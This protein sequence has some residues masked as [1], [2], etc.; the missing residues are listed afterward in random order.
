[1]G[2]LYK[3]WPDV[4][5]RYRSIPPQSVVHVPKKDWQ[6][7]CQRANSHQAGTVESRVDHNEQGIEPE[8]YQGY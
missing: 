4:Y 7:G 3:V 1:M 5:P 6:I 8:T 2:I